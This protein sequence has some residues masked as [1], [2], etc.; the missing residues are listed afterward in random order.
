MSQNINNAKAFTI[1]HEGISNQI[2]TDCGICELFNPE[3]NKGPHPEVKHFTALWDTGATGTVITKNVVDQLGLQ[4]TGIV[5]VF[6]ANG[7]TIMNTYLVNVFLPSNVGIHSVVVTE[8]NLTGMDV[9]IG[10]DIIN[11]GDFSISNFDGKTVC[12][13]QVPSLKKID[14][15]DDMNKKDHTPIVK[16]KVLGRNDL[17]HCGS[18]LKYKKCCMNM[19]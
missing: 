13:F 10:M 9:L 18:K 5:N 1:E 16:Q 7:S 17:C 8:G 11:Q 15:V 4:P 3:L 14:Y 12:S 2:K 6:H 19:N